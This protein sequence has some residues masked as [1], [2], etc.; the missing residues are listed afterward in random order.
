MYAIQAQE[1]IKNQEIEVS[2]Y[3][4]EH[5]DQENRQMSP[6][7]RA[8]NHMTRTRNLLIFKSCQPREE[9]KLFTVNVSNGGLVFRIYNNSYSSI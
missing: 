5:F 1:K 9:E 8:Y 3:R 2:F 6:N 7:H 4:L